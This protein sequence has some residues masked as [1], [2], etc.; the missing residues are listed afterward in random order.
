MSKC[1]DFRDMQ[2][3]IRQCIKRN[4]TL[5]QFLDF[6]DEWTDFVD[7]RRWIPVVERLPEYD[8]GDACSNNVLVTVEDTDGYQDV[9]MGFLQ[10]GEWWT[11]W[12]YGCRSL[13]GER[14]VKRVVAWMPMPEPYRGE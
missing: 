6:T 7:G 11:V 1:V 10:E 8:F 3:C 14:L 12:C 13:E 4:M 2:E 5:R 9:Y